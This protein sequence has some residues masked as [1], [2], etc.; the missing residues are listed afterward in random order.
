MLRQIFF[1][2]ILYI[3]LIGIGGCTSYTEDS[4]VGRVTQRYEQNIIL[5]TDSSSEKV[6][7]LSKHIFWDI[8]TIGLAEMWYDNARSSY[9]QYVVDAQNAATKWKQFRE[10]HL[11]MTENQLVLELGPPDLVTSDGIGGKILLYES[12]K[13]E[14]KTYLSISHNVQ[15]T[16]FGT[17][18]GTSS[19]GGLTTYSANVFRLWFAI[20]KKGK[21]YKIN[22]RVVE[23]AL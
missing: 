9:Y 2:V 6:K 22:R 11:G 19:G 12:S 21:V 18:Y 8:V 20:N 23:K 1:I 17:A 3:G 16:G 10:R 7:K 15:E 14:G 13:A 5:K 4:L